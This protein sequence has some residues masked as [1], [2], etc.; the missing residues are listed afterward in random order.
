M[1]LSESSGSIDLQ[2]L[3]PGQEKELLAE[4][5]RLAFGNNLYVYLAAVALAMVVAASHWPYNPP[6]LIIGWLAAICAVYSARHYV[7]VLFRGANPGPDETGPWL[8]WLYAGSLLGGATWGVGFFILFTP[9]SPSL[10]LFLAICLSG[11]ALTAAL[12]FASQIMLASLFS[13]PAAL[14]LSLR[15]F[16]SG[17]EN[18]V[19]AGLSILIGLFVYILASRNLQDSVVK[20]LKLKFANADLIARLDSANQ[21]FRILADSSFEGIA[22]HDN[23][24]VLDVNNA[25]LKS[26]GYTNRRELVGRNLMEVVKEEY[27]AKVIQNMKAGSTTPYEIT[28]VDANGSLVPVEVQGKPMPYNGK[29]ARVVAVRNLSE[30]MLAEKSLRNAYLFLQN[31]IDTIPNPIFY[32]DAKGIYTGC[33]SAFDKFLGKSREEIVG[34]SVFDLS[35]K[36]LAEKYYQMDQDLFLQGGVQVYESHVARPGEKRSD[37]IFY[38]ARFHQ[39]DG[40]LGGLVG[41]ILDITD[42]KQTQKDLEE[43]KERAEEAAAVR[44][45]FVSLVAH[46]L[47]SPIGTINNIA[48]VVISGAAGALASQH[49]E[50]LKRVSGM[51]GNMINMIDNLLNITRLSSGATRPVKRAAEAHWIVA[52]ALENLTVTADLK[53]VA[54][55]NMV[56]EGLQMWADPFLIAEALR[57]LVT[58]AVK[59]TRK[60][61]EV[62]ITAH[63]DKTSQFIVVS[64]TGVGVPPGIMDDV[65][66]HDVKTCA[67]GTA[68]ERG[69]GF[70][71]PLSMDIMRAHGG[72]ITAETV[73]GKGSVFALVLPKGP[74][75]G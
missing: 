50:L 20:A 73:V 14:L 45:K 30:R 19:P 51:C 39:P 12:G 25:L 57:N 29:M 56:P 42:L 48:G 9:G 11:L 17:L 10:Q 31:L 6:Y 41:V 60:G 61:G 69:S 46:D 49:A 15:F 24:L 33:N 67:M 72:T 62:T 35:P 52:G 55:K 53:G 5:T 70:G 44:D 74:Q 36:E 32:K 1:E 3:S 23:G 38:K 28:I 18:G 54:I 40:A 2:H 16:T 22:I 34:K 68:G 64:D 21:R 13:I 27:R 71:L 63:A 8:A 66:R 26:F 37:V 47:R 43:A 65:F 58:N 75:E 4:R 59:F 7:G